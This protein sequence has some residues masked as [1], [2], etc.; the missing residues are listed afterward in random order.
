MAISG[1]M[2]GGRNGGN[3]HA[4]GIFCVEAKNDP[5]KMSTVLRLRNPVQAR[6]TVGVV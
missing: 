2:V 4:T 3:G 5:A 1:D 6:P